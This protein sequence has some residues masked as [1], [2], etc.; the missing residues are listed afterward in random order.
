[1][2]TFIVRFIDERDLSFRGK[3]RHVASGEESVFTDER[4]LL[5]FF[6]TMNVLGAMART[7]AELVETHRSGGFADEESSSAPCPDASSEEAGM[8]DS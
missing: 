4:G 3:V 5:S 8:V 1:M 2:A 7:N 6:E